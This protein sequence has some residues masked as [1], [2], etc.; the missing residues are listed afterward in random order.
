M[1]DPTRR[2]FLKLA[3]TGLLGAA[4]LIA[5]GGILRFFDYESEPAARTVIDLGSA[6]KYPVGS[7]TVLADIPAILFA[8]PAGFKALSLVCTHLGCTVE[9]IPSGFECP[10]HGSRYNDK[11]DIVKGPARRALVALRV[12]TTADGHL[13]LHLV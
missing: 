8:T 13:L 10:C 11:G 3:T 2:D 7:R 1:S 9:E 12:E 6:S 5:L 4:G